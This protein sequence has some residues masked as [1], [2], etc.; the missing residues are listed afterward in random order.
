MNINLKN[1]KKYLD[2]NETFKIWKFLGHDG[3]FY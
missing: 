1:P 3:M 2:D